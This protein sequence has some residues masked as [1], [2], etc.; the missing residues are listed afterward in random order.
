M[1]EH[2]YDTGTIKVETVF[3]N[4]EPGIPCQGFRV[5]GNIEDLLKASHQV[6][7]ATIKQVQSLAGLYDCGLW[8]GF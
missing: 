1:R 4:Q 2:I 8:S 7:C 5:T 3:M 6:K